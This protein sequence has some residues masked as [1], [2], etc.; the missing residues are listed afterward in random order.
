MK[1]RY[2]T[3][4]LVTALAGTGLHFLYELCP[5]PL[6][7]LIAPVNESVWEHLK[8]LFWPFLAASWFLV[9]K[10]GG[11]GALGACMAAALLTPAALLGIYYTLRCGFG[12]SGLVLDIALYYVVLA[13]G[14]AF[15]YIHRNSARLARAAGTLAMLAAILASCLLVFSIAAPDFPIFWANE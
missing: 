5:N 13:G 7:A 15:V 4:F 11:S 12:A 3:V 1:R 8:L 10:A 2:L 14:F 6:F 9:K